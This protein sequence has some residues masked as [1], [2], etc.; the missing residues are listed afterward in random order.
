MIIKGRRR[1]KPKKKKR[2]KTK[3]SVPPWRGYRSNWGPRFHNYTPLT[4]PR[5]KL[6]DEALEVELI[7][8]PRNTQTPRNADT[9]KHCQYHRKYGHTIEGCQTLKDKIEELVQDGH[10]CKFVK[11]STATPRSPQCD[12]N[13]FSK[14]MERSERRDTRSLDDYR[15]TAR[16]K[17]RESPI[18]RTRL[19]SE[20]P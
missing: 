10:L 3:A 14:D 11:T 19:R 16:R 7:A 8:I 1:P 17:Q 13:Y 15:S 12:T 9:A 18:R 6:L 5:G 4:V 2:R 20:S